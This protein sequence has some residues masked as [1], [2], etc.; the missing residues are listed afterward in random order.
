FTRRPEQ[1]HARTSGREASPCLLDNGIAA[2]QI[3]VGVLVDAAKDAAMQAGH[4]LS[5]G[6]RNILL[7][8]PSYLKNIS[9]DGVFQWFSAVFAILGDKARD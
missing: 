3:I 9:D 7:A 2:K 1:R 8:P 5:E 4:A 6:A